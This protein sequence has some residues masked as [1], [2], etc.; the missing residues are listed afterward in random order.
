MAQVK[1]V[2]EGMHTV[3]PAL[4]IDGAAEALAFYQR[5]FGAQEVNRAP[6]PSG[7][8]VWHAMIKIGDSMVF[9]NDAFP[10]MGAGANKTSL[11]LYVDNADAA[12]QRAVEAGAQQVMPMA[13]MF[14]G[15]R[16]GVVT[17]PWG[18]RWTFAQHIKDM[19]PEEMQRAQ[20]EAAKQWGAKKE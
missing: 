4:T 15:D 1:A 10:E 9:V 7:K 18:N 20:D 14:W 5:A 11:W 17:D 8:K 16:M 13:D 2:P 3:T 19:T 6:D 12:F